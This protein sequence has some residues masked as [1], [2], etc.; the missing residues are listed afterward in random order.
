MF[1]I[2]QFPVS[3]PL[4]VCVTR[5]S[6][7]TGWVGGR[8]GAQAASFNT[9]VAVLTGWAGGRLGARAASF[10]TQVAVVTARV[11]LLSLITVNKLFNDKLL[12]L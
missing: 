12:F 8:L 2:F 6:V 7:L 3:I 4:A 9:Q 5:F 11:G 10:N 1:S